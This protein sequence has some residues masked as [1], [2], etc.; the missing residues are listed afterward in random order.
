VVPRK[1][2]LNW[3]KEK[4]QLKM[5]IGEVRVARDLDPKRAESLFQ[6]KGLNNLP[7]YDLARGT[8]TPTGLQRV[9]GFQRNP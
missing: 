9:G 7:S 2:V 8:D 1:I 3:E 4:M 5:N 6:R